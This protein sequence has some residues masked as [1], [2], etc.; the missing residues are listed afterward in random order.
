MSVTK[1]QGSRNSFGSTLPVLQPLYDSA[2]E[3]WQF[4][5]DGEII[6]G[7]SEECQF[8]LNHDGVANLHC[9]FTLRAGI[10]TARRLNGRVWINEI[11]ISTEAI[12]ASG[13]VISI[14]PVTIQV[15]ETARPPA[16]AA[17]KPAGTE[18]PELQN[19]LNSMK[20][21]A[22]A[23]QIPASPVI[24][25]APAIA[26]VPFYFAATP[27]AS[28]PPLPPAFFEDQ[29]AKITAAAESLIRQRTHDLE[30]RE[31]LL[32]AREQQLQELEL[33]IRDRERI[34]VDRQSTLDERVQ[35]LT[36]QKNSIE[37][38]RTQVD[39]LREK[40]HQQ[41]LDLERRIRQQVE[42]ENELASQLEV[43]AHSYAQIEQ[44]RS[45]LSGRLHDIQQRETGLEQQRRELE[46]LASWIDSRKTEL[47]ASA[48][49]VEY[50]AAELQSREVAL[51][52]AIANLAERERSLKTLDETLRERQ[53]ALTTS[54]QHAEE[55]RLCMMAAETLSLDAAAKMTEAESIRIAAEEKLQHAE[56]INQQA[57]EQLRLVELSRSDLDQKRLEFEAWQQEAQARLAQAAEL[58]A[59]LV[60]RGGSIEEEQA[61][62]IHAQQELDSQL[63]ALSLQSAALA[64]QAGILEQR[65]IQLDQRE[66]ELSAKAAQLPDD[67]STGTRSVEQ[68]MAIAAEKESAIR[69][70]QEAARAMD[71]VK[72]AQATLAEKELALKSRCAEIEDRSA[73]LADRVLKLKAERDRIREMHQQ[74][75][76]STMDAKVNIADVH[77]EHQRLLH[78]Q[79]VLAEREARAT[80]RENAASVV[81]RNAEAEREALQMSHKD[82]I[83]ERNALMQFS[84]DLN[85][86]A[87]GLTERE[88]TVAQQTEELRN[89]FHAMNQ[90]SSEL[91]R[92]E[93][94]LNLRAAELHRHVTQFKAEV[95]EQRAAAALMSIAEHPADTSPGSGHPVDLSHPEEGRIRVDGEREQELAEALQAAKA[96]AERVQSERDALLMAV[97]ELQQAMIDAR[98]DVEE[99]N[100][101]RMEASAQEQTLTALY[102][103]IEE[104]SGQLQLLESRLRQAE[105][106]SDSL[107]RQLQAYQRQGMDTAGV[108]AG[109]AVNLG[110]GSESDDVEA[111][112]MRQLEAL[113]A[114]LK[115]S[116]EK[117]SQ[118]EDSSQTPEEQDR[119]DLNRTIEELRLQNEALQARISDLTQMNGDKDARGTMIQVDELEAQLSR[120]TQVI[121]DRDDLIRELRT[122]LSQ[123]ISQSGDPSATS[124]MD[125]AELQNEARELDRR[126]SLLDAREEEVRE[127]LRMVANSE[128]EV[129]KQRRQ[130]L[131]ARQQLELARTEIQA[132][133]KQHAAV[134]NY[135]TEAESNTGTSREQA[136]HASVLRPGA[137]IF[138]M[139]AEPVSLMDDQEEA[140]SPGAALDLRS[141]LASLF[142]LSGRSPEPMAQELF[143]AEEMPDTSE[144]LGTSKPVAL[145]FGDDASRIVSGRVE[146]PTLESSASTSSDDSSDDFVRDYMEQLLSRSRKSA[147]NS[148]PSE[149]SGGAKG[150]TTGASTTTSGATKPDTTTAKSPPKV[151]SYIDEYMSGGMMPLE[152]NGGHSSETL[153][154]ITGG[155]PQDTPMVPRVKVDVEKLRQNMDSF[156]SVSTHSIE[157]ALVTH[158]LRTERL[159][160]NGRIFLVCV[161]GFMS[162]FLSIA[163]YKNIINSPAL[164]WVTLIATVGAGL[165]LMRKM[166]AIKSKGKALARC[167]ES[168][169]SKPANGNKLHDAERTISEPPSSSSAPEP[170]PQ[171]RPPVPD[172]KSSTRGVGS[173]TTSPYAA[174]AAV[175]AIEEMGS[176]AINAAQGQ[177]SE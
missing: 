97:R 161:M 37:E 147:G 57:V 58:D 66:A 159:S 171:P 85:S 157:K 31:R 46:E 2:R 12:L 96:Q 110:L 126:A 24:Q 28:P 125:A 148:L 100:R 131:D 73:E 53:L 23:V 134:A 83:C 136:S 174:I 29:S 115:S 86:R 155:N 103:T 137:A 89:R 158:A 140:T 98:T 149:L 123:Q 87:S 117:S 79:A 62:L 156:R 72:T 132:A 92:L 93:N 3:S 173:G 163:N 21:A 45:E 165:E 143:S 88:S 6:C 145:H 17:S 106:H 80:E 64:D 119:S 162:V 90:Q 75:Q 15:D 124:G 141:E 69:S 9:A 112:L 128:E 177:K 138:G 4:A 139:E 20:P 78:Q 151:K 175:T 153:S 114:E 105:I 16:P 14:G 60:N 32:Q 168:F 1:R 39:A 113:K 135:A 52:E 5:A 150:K 116:G 107:E 7:A 54:E 50:R 127:R 42:Q 18:T 77:E 65:A 102:Q 34:C 146:E 170:E 84:Q 74:L 166:Y 56:Q 108:F 120:A 176:I 129:E 160:I 70:R 26:S 41:K 40:L 133:M 27:P 44:T 172:D 68:L 91:T 81:L 71:E 36:E 30:G 13:D 111:E 118:N 10:L 101:L 144:P 167:E 152:D 154:A 122:R 11:P 59:Q 19:S 48:T 121:S 49:A 51:Q 99:A 82:L 63:Q 164:T 67:T 22:I 25:A 47:Q 169:A 95:R 8:R 55:A 38:Q 33:L 43:S 61:R 130:L 142:G 94:E 76:A 104:R 109:S 35:V